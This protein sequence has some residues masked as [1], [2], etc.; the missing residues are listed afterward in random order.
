MTKVN[1]RKIMIVLLALYTA[2]TLYFL[3]LGF[4]RGFLGLDSNLRYTLILEAIPLHYPMGRSFQI[5]FFEYGNFLVFIPFG[6][7]IPL[8]FPCSFRR[9]IILFILSI[10][11]IEAIQML[12]RL[13][14]FDINDIII[15]SLGAAVGFAAQRLVTDDRDKLKGIVK[16]AIIA[17]VLAIGTILIVGGINYY[18]D[19]AEGE[20]VA[21]HELSVKDGSIQW[22]EKLSGFTVDQEEITPQINLYNITDNNKFSYLLDGAYKTLTGYAAISDDAINA[23]STES[24]EIQFISGG[25]VIY[26][27]GLSATSGENQ[28]LSFEVPLDGVHD[29]TIKVISEGSNQTT[30]IV[31]WDTTLT[32]VN[33]GQKMINSIKSLF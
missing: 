20:T 12:T 31:I 22:A 16:A 33:P 25:T 5:W 21:L 23:G 18:L 19:K 27:V 1:L 9:F 11:F 30:N 28:V 3:Y 32:E 17:I 26:S 29:F 2:L 10:T 4:N 7:I 6:I 8:L 14:A 24:S 13:G 15:N